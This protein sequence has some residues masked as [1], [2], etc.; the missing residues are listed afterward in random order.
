MVSTTFNKIRKRKSAPNSTQNIDLNFPKDETEAYFAALDQN[1]TLLDQLV[2]KRLPDRQELERLLNR[3]KVARLE[4]LHPSLRGFF[5]ARFRSQFRQSPP[6]ASARSLEIQ[7][8]HS[9]H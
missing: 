7:L 5:S 4:V 9:V 6:P 3:E 1:R 8:A 2:Q